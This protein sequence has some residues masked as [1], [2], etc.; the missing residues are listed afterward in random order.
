MTR[1]HLRSNHR[2]CK[3]CALAALLFLM[4]LALGAASPGG[5]KAH[6]IRLALAGIG[7]AITGVAWSGVLWKVRGKPAMIGYRTRPLALEEAGASDPQKLANTISQHLLGALIFLALF[8]GMWELIQFPELRALD[9]TAVRRFY[10]CGGAGVTRVMREISDAGGR[11][12]MVYT[13]PVLLIGLL[14]LRRRASALFLSSTM[15]GTF[16]LEVLFKSLSHRARPNLVHG[17]HFDSFPSGHT[18]AAAILAGCLFLLLSPVCRGRR[19]RMLLTV[20]A[21]VWPMLMGTTRVYLGRH[22]L[23]DVVA[24]ILLGAG[25]V[26]FCRALSGTFAIATLPTVEL[27]A[28]QTGESR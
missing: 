15:F 10:H 7:L 25:W 22:Y 2:G 14:V 27:P 4:L 18:L 16:G 19:Q 3:L 8:G 17:A 1:H 12:L 28:L 21:L 6:P 11:D 23:T 26:C 24:A 20:C 13:I 9:E 5:P